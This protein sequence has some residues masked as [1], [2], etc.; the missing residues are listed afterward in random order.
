APPTPEP[1]KASR[2]TL[3]K[4][5]EQAQTQQ[6]PPPQQSNYGG[7]EEKSRQEQLEDYEKDYLQRIEQQRKDDERAYQEAVEA[8]VKAKAQQTRGSLPKG[9]E[10]QPEPETPKASRGTLPKGF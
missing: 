2:G 9:F 7:S 3:P 6:A 8:E 10:P 5:M 1:P 4:G